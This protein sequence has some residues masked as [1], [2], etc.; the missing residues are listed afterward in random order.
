VDAYDAMTSDRVYRKAMS[1][2]KALAEIKKN[3]GT[4][5]DPQIVENFIDLLANEDT[6]KIDKTRPFI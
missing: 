5:F 4:Q 6:E 2:E 3:A 1:K